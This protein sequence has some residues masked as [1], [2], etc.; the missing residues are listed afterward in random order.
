MLVTLHQL[1]VSELAAILE[2]G[3]SFSALGFVHQGALPPPFVMRR[4]L[5]MV[6]AGE[7]EPWWSPF[8]ILEGPEHAI[9]GGCAFKGQPKSGRVEVLYGV[10]KGCRGRGIA[11]AAVRA[12]TAVA[13][14]RGAVEVLAEIEPHNVASI[15]VVEACGFE[16]LSERLA[17][18]GK[19]VRQWLLVRNS[20]L[21]S[22]SI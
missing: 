2:Q 4:A 7:P 13:F 20:C 8:L 9:V 17:G 22:C 16:R 6:S 15:R 11:G 1:N 10:S 14:A 5:E 21:A 3:S 19:V 18:D 12:L